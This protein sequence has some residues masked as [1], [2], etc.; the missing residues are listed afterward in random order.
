MLNSFKIFF[1]SVSFCGFLNSVIAQ[2]S[3]EWYSNGALVYISATAEVHVLG[4]LHMMSTTTWE[5]YGLMQVH[6]NLYA[7]NTMQ[8]RGTGTTRIMNSLVNVG[9]VQTIYNTNGYAVRSVGSSNLGINDGSFYNLEL[10][11]SLGRV[12]LSGGGNVADV[13]NSVDFNYMGTVN[14]ILTYDPLAAVP[15]NGSAY[16][17]VFGIMNSTATLATVMPDNTVSTNGNMSST[18]NGYVQGK[19]RRMINPAG[20]IYGFVLG[21]EP[22]GA[23]AQRGM[24][25][26]HLNFGANNY[27]VI[28]SYFQ[29]GSDNTDPT[30]PIE[31][32][33]YIINYFG[34]TDH[35][36][37]VFNDATGIGTGTYEAR[38]WPQDHN[39][40][41]H[42]IWVITKDDAIVGTANDC[43]PSST[44][45]DR[46]GLD[47]FS[48]IGVAATDLATLPIELLNLTATPINENTIKVDW[49]TATEINT[50]YFEIERTEDGINHN[51]VGLSNAAGNS[52]NPIS[53][54]IDDE[55]C[56]KDVLYFYRIK[57][58]D[59]N[60]T[61]SYSNYASAIIPSNL[62]TENAITVFPNPI[63]S[64]Q[65]IVGF[66]L[67]NQSDVQIRIYNAIGQLI[68]ENS[69]SERS[70][71]EQL[72]NIP[73]DHIANG[74]YFIEVS[75]SQNTL[76]NC[77]LIKTN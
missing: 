18:D 40:P 2:H 20:G 65:L 58:F 62:I 45:L 26:I 10:G 21:L 77:K 49:T 64:G 34:G 42:T 74:A 60:N 59:N 17:S 43:G 28:E 1:L 35:G 51:V 57:T 39:F 73:F 70:V 50:D 36:E 71:G 16:P 5:N 23:G 12:Y 13:R 69:Y 27:D 55:N 52:S 11:N 33:G 48:E 67:D 68:Q 29:S 9:E 76:G 3:N 31:C 41:A 53:Y 72:I 15:A 22:A 56:L 4:D 61:Y 24:Q 47:G 6:G 19:L 8:Q 25:Y 14:R 37:W 66:S 38:V 63:S 32:S 30:S 44:G 54:F 46:S 75:D 7:S